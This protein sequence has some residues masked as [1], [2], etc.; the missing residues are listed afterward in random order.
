MSS[1]SERAIS[2]LED[3]SAMMFYGCVV[4]ALASDGTGR[5]DA[6]GQRL[7]SV[8]VQKGGQLETAPFPHL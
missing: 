8:S 7:G 2:E 6:S 1:S 5:V 3:E 4:V